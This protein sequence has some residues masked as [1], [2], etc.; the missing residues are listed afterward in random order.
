MPSAW[1][2]TEMTINDTTLNLIIINISNSY[3]IISTCMQY[4]LFVKRLFDLHPLSQEN[5]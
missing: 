1:L 5:T 2:S 4:V 3:N